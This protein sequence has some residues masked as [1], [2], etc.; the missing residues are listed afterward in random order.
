MDVGVDQERRH[1]KRLGHHHTCGL[2]ADAGERLEKIPVG[3]DLARSVKNL[4]GHRRKVSRLGRGET[5]LLDEPQDLVGW[6][7]RHLLWRAGRCEQRRCDLVDLFVGGLGRERNRNE[8]GVRIG[9]IEGD[10]WLG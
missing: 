7:R 5:D 2:V 4:M 6:Q 9:V 3:N 8:E 1:A 10:R